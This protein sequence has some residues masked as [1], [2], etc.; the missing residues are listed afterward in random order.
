MSQFIQHICIM[1]IENLFNFRVLIRIIID[2]VIVSGKYL[3]TGCMK[4]TCA[5]NY[6]IFQITVKIPESG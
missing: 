6:C 3:T 4:I 2:I 5:I 1:V